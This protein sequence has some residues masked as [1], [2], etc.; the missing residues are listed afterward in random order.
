MK[1]LV[2]IGA[3]DFGREVLALVNRVNNAGQDDF[4]ILGFVDD[5]INMQGQEIAGLPVLGTID[6]INNYDEELYVVCSIGTG[7]IRKS[8]I[9]KIS[10]PKVVFPVIID[11]TV[12]LLGEHTFGEGVIICANNVISV[13]VHVG[14]HSIVNL[15]C[16]LGHDTILKDYCTVNPGSNLSGFVVLE[17]CVDIGTGTKIIQHINV[18]ENTVI[19]AGAVVVRD[20]PKSSVAV[21]CPAKVVK[22]K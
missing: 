3:G 10:N 22:S 15:S 18:G 9:N 6:W 13:N 4:N 2:I 20:I 17:E 5:N 16:T 19:G 8:V 14:N 11:P 12:I 7:N 21:G 1:E